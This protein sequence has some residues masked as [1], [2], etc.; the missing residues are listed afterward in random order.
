MTETT[1]DLQQ[2]KFGFSDAELAAHQPAFRPDLF[3]GQTVLISGGGGGLGRAMAWVYARLGARVGICGRTLDKLEATAAPMREQGLEVETF[4]MNIRN[5][6]EVRAFYEEVTTRLGDFDVLV[7]SAGGQFPQAAIDFSPNGWKAVIDTNL[8][9][10]WFMMQEAAKRWRDAKRPGSIVN[11]VAVTE[12]GIP[13]VAHT[14]AA[15]SGVV[16]LTKTVAVEWAEYGIRVNCVSPGAINTD[17]LRVYSEDSVQRSMRC[18][19]MLRMGDAFDIADAAVF[20]SGPTGK[21][22]TGENLIVDGGGHLWG[23]AWVAGKPA[24][25]DG[26]GS[27][28]L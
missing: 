23:V 7:N 5:V 18:N 28:G 15:R 10:T 20:L 1:N 8:N 12:R 11:I 27:M 14:I 19:P 16:G 4:V 3:K 9:G 2:P 22:V 24:Y 13:G 25:F 17:G 6:D 26:P 21:F